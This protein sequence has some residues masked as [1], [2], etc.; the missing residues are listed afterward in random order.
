MSAYG[1]R[2]GDQGRVRSD[3]AG[4]LAAATEAVASAVAFC[5]PIDAAEGLWWL[6][7][8]KP[9]NEKALASDLERKGIQYFLPLARHRRIYGGRTFQVEIPLFSSYLF[10]CGGEAERYATLMTHRAV[11]VIAV[12]DQARLKAELRHVYRATTSDQPVD[13][14]PGI[15]RGRRCRVMRG[16]L[17]GL[18][19]V[20]IRRRGMCRVYLG[21]EILGQSAEV[22]VDPS[23]LEVID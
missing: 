8:T 10:L 18:E 19:G 5:C 17:A 14:Y 4:P 23:L 12:A 21:V 22:E 1:G 20:V 11:Q 2:R 9:R 3:E 16:S 13:L 7:H 6:V 15:K